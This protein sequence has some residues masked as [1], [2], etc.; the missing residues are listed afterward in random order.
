MTF[1]DLFARFDW[2][3]IPNCPGR[4]RLAGGVRV[5]AADLVRNDVVWQSFRVPAAR[6]EVRVVAFADGGGLISYWRDDGTVIHTLNDPSGLT[7]KLDEFGI[8]LVGTR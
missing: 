8:V 2:A 3:P 1:D 7:R 6:D 4:Y 5:S